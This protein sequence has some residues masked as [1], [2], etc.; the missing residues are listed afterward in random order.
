M[1]RDVAD[2]GEWR[3]PP[4]TPLGEGEVHVWRIS[5]DVEA[6]PLQPLLSPDERQRAARF[7]RDEHRRRYVAAHGAL[8]IILGAYLEAA[9]ES[10]AFEIGEHGKP[11]LREPFGPA[12]TRVEFNLSHS[13]DLA[14]LAVAHDH[15]VGVDVER[16]SE[17]EHLELAERFFSRAE[18][19]ALRSL[20]NVAE[21]LDAGFFA[22]WTRKEAYLKATGYGIARGLHHFDV[23]LAPSVEAALLADRRDATATQRWTMRSFVPAKG[24]SGAVVAAAPL[25]NLMLFDADALVGRAAHGAAP[26]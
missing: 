19:D 4:H 26:R 8:R 14:L 2:A 5:L 15:P 13:A 12:G 9:P 10:L 6:D 17:V 24:Y 16:W 20:A 25:R 3:L 22:A 21:H 11:S 1:R 7:H 18:R 23:T